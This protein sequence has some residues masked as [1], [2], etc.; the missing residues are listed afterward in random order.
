[1]PKCPTCAK[2]VYMAEEVKAGACARGTTTTR[3]TDAAADGKVWHKMGCFKCQSCGTMLEKG[4]EMSKKGDGRTVCKDCYGKLFGPK[5][6]GFGGA[7]GGVYDK[8]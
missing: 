6:F 1:M 8:Q 4:K 3:G 7:M 2:E 5:G